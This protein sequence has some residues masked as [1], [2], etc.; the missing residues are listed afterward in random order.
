MEE[1][2]KCSSVRAT[3]VAEL[4][5]ILK[6]RVVWRDVMTDELT[7][8]I[9]KRKEEFLTAL[10]AF[11]KAGGRIPGEV[12][13]PRIHLFVPGHRGFPSPLITGALLV[14]DWKKVTREELQGLIDTPVETG[15][16]FTQFLANWGKE[17][18]GGKGSW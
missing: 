4:N 12:A 10:T 13:E 6:Q 18:G 9:N 7:R 1:K 11:I 3:Q 5:R 8:A 2:E 14:L 15:K 16:H 17:N